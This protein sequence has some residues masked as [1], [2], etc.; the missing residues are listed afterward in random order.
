[1]E[2]LLSWNALRI[3]MFAKKITDE[4][5]LRLDD[6]QAYDMVVDFRQ[7][8]LPLVESE[9]SFGILEPDQDPPS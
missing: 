1:M 9:V 5:I 8:K 6:L 7:H 2:L 3:W 4:F